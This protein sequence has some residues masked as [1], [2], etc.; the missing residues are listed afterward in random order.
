MRRLISS[1]LYFLLF[2]SMPVKAFE[3]MPMIE[4][5][6]D[7]GTNTEK[8]FQLKNTSEQPLPVEVF[9]KERIVEGYSREKLVDSEDFFIFPPQIMVPPGKTQMIKVKYIGEPT[10]TA[11]SYR[12]VFSQLPIKD[13]IEQSSIKMLFQIGALAFVSPGHAD[14]ILDAEIRPND[15]DDMVLALTNTGTGVLA[16]PELKFEVQ[17]GT[18]KID[19]SWEQLQ[20]LMDRQF[21]VPGEKVDV[22]VDTLSSD[23]KG[24]LAIEVKGL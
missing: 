9:A 1:I 16:L 13:S 19:W 8:F 7:V 12:L 17:S 10:E 22:P 18:E 11:K 20:P 4:S 2:L 21:L 15:G 6:S 23:L 24:E 5:F 3:L 14:Y